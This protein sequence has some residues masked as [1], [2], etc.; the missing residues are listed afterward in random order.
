MKKALLFALALAYISVQ[1]YSQVITENLNTHDVIPI[2]TYS[3]PFT[4]NFDDQGFTDGQSI[5]NPY[6][7]ANNGETFTFTI[8]PTNSSQITS[9]RYQTQENSCSSTGLSHIT[10]G[11]FSA[12][13]WTIETTSGNEINLVRMRFNNVFSCFGGFSYNITVEGFKDNVS[14]GTQSHTVAGLNSFFIAN[15]NFDNVDK[16]VITASDLANL[17]MDDITWEAATPTATIPTVTTTAASAIANT[18]ATLAGE[19]TDDGGATVAN[20]GIVY[21]QTSENA[22][23]VIGGTGVVV[24]N[25]GTGTG[26]FSESVGGLA[27]GTEY[28]FKAYAQNSEGISYGAVSTFTTT[29]KGWTG[30]TD[31]DW[32]TSSNWSPNSVPIST[33][34]VVIPNVTNQPIISVS[35]G[36]VA[37]DITIDGSASLTIESGGS[38]IVSGSASGEIT[39]NR[40]IDFVSGNLNGW[41][42]MA[43]PVVGETFDDAYVTANDIAISG[44]N[45]GIASYNTAGDSW[46]YLQGGGSGTFNSGQGYSIK[47]GSSTGNISFTGTLN[48]DNSGVDVVLS[49]N[50]NRFNLLGNPYASYLN[51][52]TFLNNEAAISDTKTLWVW[53]QTIGTHGEYEVKTIPDAFVV[54]PAQGFFVQANTGGGT[55]N[56]EESNQIHSNSDT[57]QTEPY[58]KLKLHISDGTI[59]NHA[60]IFYLADASEGLDVGYDGEIF[61]GNSSSFAVY[62][63]LVAESD[64]RAFQTQSLPDSNYE[65]MVIPVGLTA[66]AN[67]EITFTIHELNLPVDLKV[68]LEDSETN[69]FA[70]LDEIGSNYTFLLNE[71]ISGVGRFYLHTST[72]S[73]TIDDTDSV[74]NINIYIP[75][76]STLRITHLPASEVN[77]RLFSI[78]GKE[79]LHRTFESNGTEDIVLPK[80][81]AGIYIVHLHSSQGSKVKKI[82]LE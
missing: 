10:A 23:P 15:S 25:N 12:S 29:G 14:T 54:A 56:F 65:N 68:F 30:A 18:S 1:S 51:S 79:L 5:G 20:R 38:L 47:R 41:Y 58:H 69:T 9:H 2:S 28:S 72:S 32:A 43:S 49:T 26:V 59:H 8:A 6:S 35:T 50:G 42:L 27:A 24:D 71:D 77:L 31:T 66:Q 4:I 46:D 22:D 61:G 82:I 44:S 19:V 75:N 13:T 74:D 39:Y 16:I 3:S 34:N 53:N 76:R 52:N 57:F 78:Q 48:T 37:N 81:A 62:T 11:T 33:D 55:F 45:R 7:I 21:S 70:R 60:T 36:A 64:G 80:M 63:H 67:T 73:L 17:G 40:S